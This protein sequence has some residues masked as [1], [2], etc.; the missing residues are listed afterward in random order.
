VESHQVS[1]CPATLVYL[2]DSDAGNPMIILIKQ[3]G[4]VLSAICLLK[5]LRSGL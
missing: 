1:I 4:F 3:L 2:E 5:Q